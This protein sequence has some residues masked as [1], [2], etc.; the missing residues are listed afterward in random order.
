MIGYTDF[1]SFRIEESIYIIFSFLLL[2][3]FY[4]YF[5]FFIKLLYNNNIRNKGEKLL[6]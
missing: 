3:F 5:D 6:C 4:K 2:L 1:H